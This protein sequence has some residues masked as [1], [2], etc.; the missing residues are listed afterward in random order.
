M[1]K[2]TVV[3]I[4]RMKQEKKKSVTMTAYDFRMARPERQ[5]K[6]VERRRNG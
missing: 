4:Q 2:V 3:D 1:K 6:Q 5:R